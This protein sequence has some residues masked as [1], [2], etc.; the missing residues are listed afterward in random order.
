MT[1]AELRVAGVGQVIFC[2]FA[3]GYLYDEISSTNALGI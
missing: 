2:D 1:L 3:S